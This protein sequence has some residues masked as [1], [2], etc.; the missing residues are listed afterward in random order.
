VSNT[1]NTSKAQRLALKLAA[2]ILAEID[3]RSRKGITE[4]LSVERQAHLVGLLAERHNLRP[5]QIE[6][7]MRAIPWAMREVQRM[8]DVIA[9]RL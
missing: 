8:A 3:Q 5:A 1:S 7:M 4:P 9:P 2:S 6:A